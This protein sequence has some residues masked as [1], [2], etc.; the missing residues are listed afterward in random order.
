MRAQVSQSANRLPTTRRP[1][2]RI[3]IPA[4]REF[5]RESV[6]LFEGVVRT[7]G[8]PKSVGQLY[9]LLFASSE[10]LSFSDLVEKSGMSKGSASQGLQLLRSLGAIKIA[11]EKSGSVVCEA[12]AVFP[13]RVVYEPEL[14]LRRLVSG[15]LHKRMVPLAMSEE[16]RLVR[17][18]LI[19]ERNLTANEFFMERVAQLETWR[20]MLKIV[21][22]VL[23]A[24]LGPRS[25]K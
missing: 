10:P 6:A 18:R 8:L 3:S 17:M 2:G 24:L 21:L 25:Q 23:A 9:G 12:D 16:N 11:E 20:H 4:S 5:S 13:R 19:A 7:L 15:V 22:P 1:S 14:A